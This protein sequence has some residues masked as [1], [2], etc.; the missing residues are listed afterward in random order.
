MADRQPEIVV[1]SSFG[2][3]VNTLCLFSLCEQFGKSHNSGK[4][5][6]RHCTNS[7]LKAKLKIFQNK[8]AVYKSGYEFNREV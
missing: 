6:A 2:T 7:N 4:M 1:N 3:I 5:H 8:D